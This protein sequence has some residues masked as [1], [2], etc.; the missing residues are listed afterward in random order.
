LGKVNNMSAYTVLD[1]TLGC[2]HEHRFTWEYPLRNLNSFAG[3]GA[4]NVLT[5]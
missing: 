2:L 1:S 4:E 3:D 5:K